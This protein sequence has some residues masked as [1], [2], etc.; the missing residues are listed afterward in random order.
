MRCGWCDHP[1]LVARFR[2]RRHR[3][4]PANEV[5]IVARIGAAPAPRMPGP[6][7]L[8]LVKG[9]RGR[10]SPQSG[11]VSRS[12]APSFPAATLEPVDPGASGAA[13]ARILAASD[14]SPS[15]CSAWSTSPRHGSWSSCSAHWLCCGS[16]RLRRDRR[17]RLGHVADR[18]GPAG[19]TRRARSGVLAYLGRAARWRRSRA[20]AAAG[21]RGGGELLPVAAWHRALRA[22]RNLALRP[23]PGPDSR[24]C[25]KR[26]PGRSRTSISRPP[27]WEPSRGRWTQAR[28]HAERH[29]PTN[30]RRAGWVRQPMRILIVGATGAIGRRLAETLLERG[31]NVVCMVRSSESGAAQALRDSGCELRGA[32]PG[33]RGFA[34]ARNRRNR[35]R[36]SPRPSDGCRRGRPHRRRKQCRGPPRDSGEAK[37]GRAPDLS[38]RPRRALRRTTSRPVSAPPRPWP[39]TTFRHLLPSRHGGGRADSESFVL[40]RSIV[41]RLLLIAF[42]AWL[43]EPDAADRRRLGRRIS[44]GRAPDRCNEGSR[45]PDRGRREDDLPGDA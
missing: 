31:E 32:G 18:A 19:R 2:S 33:G 17:A 25:D 23:N 3:R 36:L 38:R 26:L 16:T 39:R 9:P 8:R 6:A 10:K 4:H 29:R 15:A 7:N 5:R 34:G 27:A 37:R 24:D 28:N 45:D 43:R 20:G 44:R 21:E 41:D 40:L 22:V 14:P 13:R 42:P 35:R 11:A 12:S 30:C 1:G